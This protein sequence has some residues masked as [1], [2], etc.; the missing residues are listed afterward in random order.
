MSITTITGYA[1]PKIATNDIYEV[2]WMADVLE[3]A[4]DC[5]FEFSNDMILPVNE[6]M[7]T[8]G[9]YD[10]YRYDVLSSLAWAFSLPVFQK[11]KFNGEFTISTYTDDEYGNTHEV[12]Q[13]IEIIDSIAFP[14][15]KINP[16]ASSFTSHT[17]IY[18]QEDL[19]KAVKEESSV[20]YELGYD[21]GFAIGEESARMDIAY[22][23]P[24]NDEPF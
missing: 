12:S 4:Q 20:S 24:F 2:T 8:E 3:Q 1:S 5:P 23:N 16:N 6:E 19:N 15:L 21:E 17:P 18:T 9:I 10:A 13:V 7:P 22:N 11:L 14:S